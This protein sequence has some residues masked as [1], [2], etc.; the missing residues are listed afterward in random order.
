MLHCPVA[1][2]QWGFVHVRY[3]ADWKYWETMLVLRRGLVALL[4]VCMDSP[5]IKGTAVRLWN[6][7]FCT[8]PDQYHT[9]PRSPLPV[10]T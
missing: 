3:E 10:L 1:V 2:K 4:L 6:C 9:E 7:A 5:M 8:T